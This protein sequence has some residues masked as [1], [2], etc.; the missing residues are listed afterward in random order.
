LKT[1]H[2]QHN[3]LPGHRAHVRALWLPVMAR[4]D[5]DNFMQLK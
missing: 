5:I 4:V 1:P 3:L 2:A